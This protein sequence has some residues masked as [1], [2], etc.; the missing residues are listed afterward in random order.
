MK[1]AC[2]IVS[3]LFSFL[4]STVVAQQAGLEE[5]TE[6]LEDAGTRL[7][8]LETRYE[9]LDWSRQNANAFI[10]MGREVDTLRLELQALGR[11]I[12]SYDADTDFIDAVLSGD[13]ERVRRHLARGADVNHP[14]S[15]DDGDSYVPIHWAPALLPDFE[16]MPEI[17]DLMLATG[18]L[19]RTQPPDKSNTLV[20]LSLYDGRYDTARKLMA[21]G[22]EKEFNVDPGWPMLVG[23][24]MMGD[25]E[26]VKALLDGGLSPNQ[27]RTDTGTTGTALIFA[28]AQG[29]LDVVRLLVERGADI[30]RTN[31]DGASALDAARY[32]QRPDVVAYLESL[33]GLG[34]VDTAIRHDY[35]EFI[36][37]ESDG[38]GGADGAYQL[39]GNWKMPVSVDIHTAPSGVVEPLYYP[40]Q[41]DIYQIP[42]WQDVLVTTIPVNWQARGEGAA[43]ISVSVR[44]AAGNTASTSHTMAVGESRSN[45]RGQLIEAAQT[46]DTG[47]IRAIIAR[48]SAYFPALFGQCMQNFDTCVSGTLGGFVVL[49]VANTS[50]FGLIGE[51]VRYN[52]ELDYRTSDGSLTPLT[53]AIANGYTAAAEALIMSGANPDLGINTGFRPIHLAADR[54]HS[55]LVERLAAAGA[56]LNATGPGLL[57]AL[58]Y[59]A[60]KGDRQ[61]IDILLS[62]GANACA[63]DDKGNTPG[64]YAYWSA[65]DAGLAGRLCYAEAESYEARVYESEAEWAAFN[66][67]LVA[68]GQAAAETIAAQQASQ[69]EFPDVEDFGEPDANEFESDPFFY[70]NFMPTPAIGEAP[71][72]VGS[73]NSIDDR[74]DREGARYGQLNFSL[75]WQ[76]YSDLDIHLTC[77]LGETIYYQNRS[78]CGGTLDVDA[79]VNEQRQWTSNPVENIVFSGNVPQGTYTLKVNLYTSRATPETAPHEFVVRMS[80][81]FGTRVWGGTV[82]SSNRTWETTLTIP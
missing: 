55:G 64:Y 81:A 20:F 8:T 36:G 63:M 57:T 42:D 60:I 82:S 43:T 74:L 32:N 21:A 31:D 49:H 62:R 70:P 73:G 39:Y 19:D 80:G 28:A 45:V 51:L 11:A 22:F 40:G 77:P 47:A 41:G 75:V 27:A 12:A 50:D 54:G 24:S 13:V 29:H 72:A 53:S 26:A 30:R 5:F 2:L 10:E 56:N 38:W 9:G 59:A 16:N 25:V 4:A 33:L 71:G 61:A 52:A 6:Q 46:F 78:T 66:E 76:G 23:F 79:N 65:N 18:R 48:H 69:F 14:Y 1:R 37:L 34:T 7:D 67:I 35:P 44:D 17:F 15:S 68:V 3:L 58:H